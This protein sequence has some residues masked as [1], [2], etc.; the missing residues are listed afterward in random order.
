MTFI[1]LIDPRDYLHQRGLAGTIFSYDGENFIVM[2][3]KGNVFQGGY[4][5][6]TLRDRFKFKKAY[7]PRSS[8]NFFENSS[9]DSLLITLVG[10]MIFFSVGMMV[11]SPS[12]TFAMSLTD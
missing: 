4:A 3:A 8:F 6:K 12:K 2:D 1:W 5:W 10:T 9:T 7:L 11:L